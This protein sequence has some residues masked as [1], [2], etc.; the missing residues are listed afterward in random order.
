MVVV[1][2][3]VVVNELFGP[4]IIDPMD[5]YYVG[6]EKKSNNTA[7]LT[8]IMEVLF[9]LTCALTRCLYLLFHTILVSFIYKRIFGHY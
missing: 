9:L 6:A 2:N 7:E 1:Q 8:A 3:E 4:V 5:V